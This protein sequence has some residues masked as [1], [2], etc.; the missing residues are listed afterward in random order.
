M[1]NSRRTVA[2]PLGVFSFHGISQNNYILTILGA[3]LNDIIRPSY[4][5]IMKI[6]GRVFM[7][8]E[9]QTDPAIQ[10]QINLLKLYIQEQTN[11][12][13]LYLRVSIG[14]FVAFVIFVLILIG[15]NW[16]SKLSPDK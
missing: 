1:D 5:Q 14:S 4:L 12:L 11:L 6:R 3:A 9:N 10:E 15:S 2:L 7:G 8:K 16:L 13:K